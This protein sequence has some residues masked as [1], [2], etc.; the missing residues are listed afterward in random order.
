MNVYFH[1]PIN[2]RPRF[3]CS[4]SIDLLVLITARK[5]S[6]RRLCFYRCVSV[7]GGGV[8]GRGACMA[9]GACMV[10]GACMAGGGACVADGGHACSAHPPADT[11]ATAYGQ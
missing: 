6:L 8:H 3:I 1:F 5:R 9:G 10:V 7:H 4:A 2:N 11:T